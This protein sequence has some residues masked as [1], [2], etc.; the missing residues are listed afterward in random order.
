M[1]FVVVFFT[2]K[3]IIVKKILCNLVH[4][5]S[6]LN[7]PHSFGLA[8]ISPAHST[9]PTQTQ[10]QKFAS[11]IFSS[12]YLRNL[13]T[14]LFR[15]LFSQSKYASLR[16]TKSHTPVPAIYSPPKCLFVVADLITWSLLPLNVP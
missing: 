4:S 7:D 8:H 5:W 3:Y 12:K 1:S 11:S 13:H 15:F 10:L 14:Q 16:Y 6:Q 9:S 2:Y